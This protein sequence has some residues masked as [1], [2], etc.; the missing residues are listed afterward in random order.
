MQGKTWY[1]NGNETRIDAADEISSF[2]ATQAITQAEGRLQNGNVPFIDD[3]HVKQAKAHVDNM[4][5]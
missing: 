4:H 2:F 5:L 1:I 3:E